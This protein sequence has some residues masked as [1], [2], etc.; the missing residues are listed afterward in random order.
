[1]VVVVVLWSTSGLEGED[2]VLLPADVT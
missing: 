1:V 2:K